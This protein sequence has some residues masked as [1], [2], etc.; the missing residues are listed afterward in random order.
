MSNMKKVVERQNSLKEQMRNMLSAIENEGRAFTKEE[1]AEFENLRD[2][3]LDIEETLTLADKISLT[4]NKVVEGELEAKDKNEIKVFANFLRNKGVVNAGEVKKGDNGVIIPTTI[5]QKIIDVITEVCPIFARATKYHK[6]GTLVIPKYVKNSGDDV[7]VAYGA[8]FVAPTSHSGKFDSITLTGFYVNALVEISEG[9][10]GDTDIDLV[11]FF[12]RKMAEKYAQFLERELLY[13]TTDKISGVVNTYDETNMKVA[14]ASKS[15]VTTDELID[16]QDKVVDA[17]QFNA[18]WYL[19]RLTRSA[20]RKLKDADKNYI[21][22]PDLTAK[23]GYTLLGKPVYTTDNI[24]ALGEA[25]VPVIFYGDFSGLAVKINKD[26][27]VDVLT[28]SYFKLRNSVGILGKAEVDAKVE[29]TQ[30]IAV[31]YSGSAE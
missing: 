8:D 31:A 1:K 11:N 4:E 14:L 5:A 10:I 28:D 20:V 3:V 19:N 16:I 27:T 12:V 23:W 24:K 18:E 15:A 2:Q 9:L 7:T 26:I 25:N 6:K 29:N 22:N 21:L 17:F 30:K 13:G